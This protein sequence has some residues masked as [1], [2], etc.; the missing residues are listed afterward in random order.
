MPLGTIVINIEQETDDDVED[1]RVTG[2][3]RVFVER[4]ESIVERVRSVPHDARF[5][6]VT[7]SSILLEH[8]RVDMQPRICTHTHTQSQARELK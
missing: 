5:Q 1:C 8:R 6:R 2:A 4:V 3:E 7:A